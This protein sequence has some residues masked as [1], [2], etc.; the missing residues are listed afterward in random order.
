MNSASDRLA[1]ATSLSSFSEVVF[2]SFIWAIFLCL[3]IL[4]A[5][6]HL[7][8]RYSH[9]D[10]VLVY[11]LSCME[12][13]LGHS[14]VWGNRGSVYGGRI[15]EG[16]MLLLAHFWGLVRTLPHF[17]S[18]HPL[19]VYAWCPISCYPGSFQG[20]WFCISTGSFFLSLP[21]HWVYNQK[22]C[23][24]IFPSAEALGCMVWPRAGLTGSKSVPL[25]FIHH[26]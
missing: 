25:I 5:S 6:L 19:P 20:G 12:R 23:S 13:S 8:S 18:L 15:E 22:L 17:Q 4:A 1:I 26:M 24:F 14:S 2:Y 11:L 7:C 21:P 10:S 3:L 9:F 16:T